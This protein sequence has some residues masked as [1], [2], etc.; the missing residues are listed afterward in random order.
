ME[1][2]WLHPHSTSFWPPR[3]ILRDCSNWHLYPFLEEAVSLLFVP[4]DRI[5]YPSRS[6]LHFLCWFPETIS[7]IFLALKFVYILSDTWILLNSGSS[8]LLPSSLQHGN[9]HPYFSSESLGSEMLASYFLWRWRIPRFICNPGFLLVCQQ[10][11]WLREERF[12]LCLPTPRK[13]RAKYGLV[14]T[15]HK[16][17]L[18][19]KH[20]TWS[21]SLTSHNNCAQLSAW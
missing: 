13:P 5:I 10:V 4:W 20:L 18:F 3:Q 21:L 17:R 7:L 9:P 15:E 16:T 2:Y 14:F 11:L 12:L 8:G 19:N 6:L 1:S